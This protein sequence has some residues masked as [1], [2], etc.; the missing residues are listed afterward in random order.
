MF[1]PREVMASLADIWVLSKSLGSSLSSK[2]WT[3]IGESL[4]TP[5]TTIGVTETHF[6]SPEEQSIRNRL[7]A[8]MR[9]ALK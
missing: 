9:P 1:T 4:N 2:R 3:S 6:R 8:G 7:V 5:E